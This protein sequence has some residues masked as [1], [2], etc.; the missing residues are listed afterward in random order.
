MNKRKKTFKLLFTEDEKIISINSSGMN[1]TF[2]IAESIF[3]A[4]PN[5]CFLYKKHEFMQTQFILNN[6][7]PFVMLIF[8][9]DKKFVSAKKYAGNQKAP[10]SVFISEP[11]VFLLLRETVSSFND[12]KGFEFT[13]ENTEVA[14]EFN[15]SGVSDRIDLP[16]LIDYLEEELKGDSEEI[17]M[18]INDVLE[19][20]NE[21]HK[22]RLRSVYGKM[23]KEKEAL[24]K[25]G[26]LFLDLLKKERQIRKN[27]T[28]QKMLT[29]LLQALDG[30]KEMTEELRN[31]WVRRY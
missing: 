18:A 4:H 13:D 12:I 30:K 21:I 31:W 16:E 7:K 9:E 23:E 25:T 24:Y 2:L 6:S 29:E 8:N 11:Y 28:D 19:N 1:E 14:E 22:A 20:A 17:S 5:G 10:F 3:S 15:L 26:S 27:I